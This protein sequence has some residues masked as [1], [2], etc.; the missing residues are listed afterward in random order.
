MSYYPEAKLHWEGADA[1]DLSDPDS[2]AALLLQDTVEELS[3][4]RP[5]MTPDIAS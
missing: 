1:G 3:G 5:V 2:E 4:H